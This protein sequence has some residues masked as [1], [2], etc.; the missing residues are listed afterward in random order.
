M[1]NL[2]NYGVHSLDTK[3]IREIDGG[4]L[5]WRK[6]WKAIESTGIIVTVGNAIDEFVDGW[7]S[8]DC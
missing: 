3:E 4:R 2:E 1:K 5:P 6:I 8:V 7:N